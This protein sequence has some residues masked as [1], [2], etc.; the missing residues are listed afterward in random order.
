MTHGA[1]QRRAMVVIGST[2]LGIFSASAQAGL[3]VS[4]S[5]NPIFSRAV[6]EYD[7]VT[8]SYQGDF[9]VFD[10]N[11]GHGP[12]TSEPLGLAWGGNNDL[13][14]ANR[15][16]TTI[17]KFA[18]PGGTI[19]G[20][21]GAPQPGDITFGPDGYL[22]SAGYF[23]GGR[24]SRYAVPGGLV[25]EIFACPIPLFEPFRSFRYNGIAF[26]PDGDLFVSCQSGGGGGATAFIVLMV[27]LSRT[28][29]LLFLLERSLRRGAWLLARTV[30][31]M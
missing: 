15:I 22:Y 19:V 3:L 18:Y 27:R 10:G 5:A 30:T 9:T 11:F 4:S 20:G 24:V 7:I 21:L 1:F 12:G 31:Y 23:F 2:L 25:Q 17:H 28:K 8:G 29:G 14:V 13:W 6:K 26:G 16:S